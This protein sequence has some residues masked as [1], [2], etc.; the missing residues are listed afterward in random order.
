MTLPF[1][2]EPLSLS[3]IKEEFGG[4]EGPISLS[5]Y[6]SGGPYVPEG[7][8][9]Y[10]KNV[11]TLIPES[12]P[13]SIG[14]F[15]GATKEML[16]V[17][18]ES[19]MWT[20]PPGVRKVSAIIVAGGGSG[21]HGAG[22][23]GGGGGGAGGVL[24]QRFINVTPGDVIP[25]IVGAGGPANSYTTY[26]FNCY[27]YC[28]G[29]EGD[30]GTKCEYC[31]TGYAYAGSNGGNSS[32]GPYVAYGGGIGGGGPSRTKYGASGGSGGGSMG[33]YGSASG[34]AGIYGQGNYGGSGIEEGT[35]GGG[36]GAGSAGYIGGGGNGRTFT[37]AKQTFSVGGG[38][39]PGNGW[40]HQLAPGGVGGGGRGAGYGTPPQ[41]GTP[42]T[43]G[44]GG[45]GSAAGWAQAGPYKYGAAGGSGVVYILI[46]DR[47]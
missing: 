20:V 4:G 45:G 26:K 35:S 12:G 16:L 15:H 24:F 19:T 14:N 8:V 41:A 37:F 29:Y 28:C 46:G 43:G 23:E 11:E 13:I 36:G 34:G 18:T 21:G 2:P 44:G 31:A 10:P 3:Q 27:D 33:F 47:P 22:D 6:Y 32:F 25:I 5:D 38:G 9:G 7:T 39:G 42:N 17:F 1:Y 30:C 40:W